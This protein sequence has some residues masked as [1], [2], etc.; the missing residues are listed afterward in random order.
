MI[1]FI[2][3]SHDET[4]ESHLFISSLKLQTNNNWKCIIYND[5]P[6]EYIKNVVN[7]FNDHRIRYFDSEKPN[8]FWGHYNR[9]KSL[10]YVDT[11]FLIQTSIQDY[12]IPTAV[13]ELSKSSVMDNDLILFN[14]LHNHFNYRTLN[15]TPKIA[16]VDWGCHMIRTNISKI[17]GIENPESPTCDGLFVEKCME[18]PNIKYYKLDKILTVHN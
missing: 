11:E 3:T 4:Y 16:H 5:G 18:Y 8:G 1:T 14:C 12:Y 13:D 2:A 10:E 17:V 7:E 15:S 6:N 9:R